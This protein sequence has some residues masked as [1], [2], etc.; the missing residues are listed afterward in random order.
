[1][2][3][4]VA[5]VLACLWPVGLA[6]ARWLESARPVLACEVRIAAWVLLFAALLVSVAYLAVRAI[7]YDSWYRA[8][9]PG[10]P[11]TPP[12]ALPRQ[13]AQADWDAAGSRQE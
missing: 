4:A 5:I 2:I 13:H 9:N 6:Y 1:L 7:G 3:G 8:Q 11:F 12:R 10:E